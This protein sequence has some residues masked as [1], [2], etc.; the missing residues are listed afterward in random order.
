MKRPISFAR[1][2]RAAA[3]ISGILEKSILAMA[4]LSDQRNCGF[5][6]ERVDDRDAEM[7]QAVAAAGL[8]HDVL[9]LVFLGDPHGAFQG[10]HGAAG[11]VHHLEG[12]VR[13]EPYGPGVQFDTHLALLAFGMRSMHA[14][15]RGLKR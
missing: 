1:A 14:C 10:A 12:L 15:G 3:W 11:A 9:R 6:A 7:A 8:Q 2:R 4:V 5:A 13:A